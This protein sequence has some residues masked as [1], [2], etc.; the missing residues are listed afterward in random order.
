MESIWEYGAEENIWTK[1]RVHNLN[2][3]DIIIFTK[4]VTIGWVGHVGARRGDE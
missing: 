3:P 4:S 2:S 1:E